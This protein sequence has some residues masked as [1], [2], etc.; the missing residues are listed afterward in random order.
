MAQNKIWFLTQSLIQF[1]EFS[2]Q[3]SFVRWISSVLTAVVQFINTNLWPPDLRKGKREV[4]S[5]ME[6]LHCHNLQESH[7]IFSHS[8]LAR[9]SLKAL[10]NYKGIEECGRAHGY[11]VDIKCFCHRREQWDEP[12]QEASVRLLGEDDSNKL[13]KFNR[14]QQ[15]TS[16]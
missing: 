7:I 10:L 8:S 16:I 1:T 11:S 3:Y 12:I 13:G 6:C 5:F 15:S 2:G 4:E 14:K 9:T